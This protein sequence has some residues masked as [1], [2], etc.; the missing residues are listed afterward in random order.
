MITMLLSFKR[1]LQEKLYRGH[2][3]RHGY[4]EVF[5]DPNENEMMEISYEDPFV[6]IGGILSGK[7]L[8]VWNRDYGEHA[9]IKH[10]LP[11]PLDPDWLPLYLWYDWKKRVTNAELSSF[12]MSAE[13]RIGWNTDEQQAQIK[14]RIESVPA[15][16]RIGT[17][18]YRQY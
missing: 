9:E 13:K 2:S 8:Y 15:L 4:V 12:T 14:A 11:Q 16:K 17:V 6:E 1:F 3:G 10:L 5:V 7:K 18:I